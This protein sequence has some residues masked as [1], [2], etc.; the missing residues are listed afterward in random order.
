[1]IDSAAAM[2][3]MVDCRKDDSTR[4]RGACRWQACISSSPA[5]RTC[6]KSTARI[7][8]SA[9]RLVQ[10]HSRGARQAGER[11]RLGAHRACPVRR[12][13]A[14][15]HSGSDGDDAG[16]HGASRAGGSHE[17]TFHRR[18]SRP[19][20][21]SAGSAATSRS[22][23]GRPTRCST[24]WKGSR[25]TNCIT[26]CATRPAASVVRRRGQRRTGRRGRGVAADLFAVEMASRTPSNSS[27]TTP[28]AST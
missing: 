22:P 2:R 24:G 14:T 9:P 10:P 21:A 18:D 16:P 7:S 13:R 11:G 3:R 4:P 12:T 15:R 8:A 20:A 26:M 5:V 27:M 25:F 19:L 1:M 28:R 6:G 23:C 17:H